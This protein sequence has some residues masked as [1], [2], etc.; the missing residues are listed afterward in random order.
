MEKSRRNRWV[1]ELWIKILAFVLVPFL[2]A[3]GLTAIAESD[4]LKELEDQQKIEMERLLSRM[5]V[6]SDPRERFQSL[7]NAISRLPYGSAD[8]MEASRNL[9][10]RN[11][12]VVELYLFDKDGEVQPIEVGE[13]VP[14]FAANHFISVVLGKAA[15]P[16]PSILNTFGGSPESAE[17][18]RAGQG[19]L[20]E[21]NSNVKTWGPLAIA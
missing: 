10:R 3:V 13:R 18:I 6:M 1:F 7:L 12:D 11:R 21:L 8:F 15:R 17:L 4:T 2:I 14:R 19:R 5:R 9:S 20:V 16:R